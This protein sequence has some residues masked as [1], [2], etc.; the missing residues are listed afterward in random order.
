M[1]TITDSG[2]KINPCFTNSA[3][4][5]GPLSSTVTKPAIV[6]KKTNNSNNNKSTVDI[7]IKGVLE[8][9][10]QEFISRYH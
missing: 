6:S 9:N 2:I 8:S 7:I 3:T 5:I 1:H 10:T 4:N